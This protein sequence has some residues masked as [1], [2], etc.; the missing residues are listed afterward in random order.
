MIELTVTE[1]LTIALFAWLGCAWVTLKVFSEI[2]Q[3]LTK[4][5]FFFVD[6]NQ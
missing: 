5:Y 6:K 4:A 1:F 3:M 2:G